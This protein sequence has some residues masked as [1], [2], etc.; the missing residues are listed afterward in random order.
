M[1]V[2]TK[3]EDQELINNYGRF[4]DCESPHE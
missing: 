3:Q 2:W 1:L 4:K